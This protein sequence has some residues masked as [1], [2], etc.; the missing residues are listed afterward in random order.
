GALVSFVIATSGSGRLPSIVGGSLLGVSIAAM[1]YTGM[2][3]YRVQGIVD[4]DMTYLMASIVL[5]VVLSAVSLHL[6][7]NGKFN[8][9]LAAA[10]GVLA[11]AIVSLHFTGMTA[12]K[13]TPLSTAGAFTDHAALQA[14]ALAIALVGMIV[15]GTG[16][17]SYLI[18]D[19][20]R[21]DS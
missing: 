4:W 21:A 9:R 8:R 15:V 10:S 17:V 14:M 19:R 5:S 1:H 11:L 16:L 20:T 13:I 2:F 7:V 6:A 3:A 12:F 18:D